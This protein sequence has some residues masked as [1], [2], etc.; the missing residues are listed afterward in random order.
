MYV[1]NNFYNNIN[2]KKKKSKR[3][4]S[5]E[6]IFVERKIFIS[7]MYWSRTFVLLKDLYSMLIIIS[8]VK[9]GSMES[10][11]DKTWLNHM[12]HLTAKIDDYDLYNKTI[13]SH[14]LNEGFILLSD[15]QK[16]STKLMNSSNSTPTI[17]TTTVMVKPTRSTPRLIGH[18]S[19]RLLYELDSDSDTPTIEDNAE[20]NQFLKV[21]DVEELTKQ[22]INLDV[23]VDGSGD[24]KF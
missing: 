2:N 17:Y 5:T 3:T 23:T 24:S 21:N 14:P 1:T 4:F 19:R 13:D 9:F 10:I 6:F 16:K 20:I 8:I 22:L 7:N 11:L 12:Q 18:R 15:N